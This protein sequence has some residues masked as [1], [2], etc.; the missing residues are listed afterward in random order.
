MESSSTDYV[1]N[2]CSI[3]N[4]HS[5]R[6]ILIGGAAVALHGYFR[7]SRGPFDVIASKPD[8]DIWYDPSY[9][10]YFNLLNAL[11]EWGKD[12]KRYQEEK[13][14][15]P[16]HSFFRFDEPAFTLDILP[17]VGG[18]GKFNE[19]FK[20]AVAIE[21]DLTTLR[22]LSIDDLIK[23]KTYHGRPKDLDDFKELI[24]LKERNKEE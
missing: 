24:K 18:L 11:E 2:I 16:Y 23:N 7:Q 1:L 17:V 22:V 14:P 8:I 19:S 10:N 12:M 21:A 5:V 15:D 13:I 4:R 9:P 20:N 3:L 6:H